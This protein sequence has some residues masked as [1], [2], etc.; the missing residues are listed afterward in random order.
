MQSDQAACEI[1]YRSGSWVD[2]FICQLEILILF[3]CLCAKWCH[4]LSHF[5]YRLQLL[6]LNYKLAVGNFKYNPEWYA[7][8]REYQRRPSHHG[9]VSTSKQIEVGSTS[10]ARYHG[11]EPHRVYL[12]KIEVS[13]STTIISSMWLGCA[14]GKLRF[15]LWPICGHYY[16]DSTVKFC[17]QFSLQNNRPELLYYS[18]VKRPLRWWCWIRF[19]QILIVPIK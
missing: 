11:R 18:R 15:K 3:I 2:L 8:A 12:Q 16:F 14:F 10:W 7:L 13:T 17:H 5:L 1:R 9:I 19:V 6:N 4:L